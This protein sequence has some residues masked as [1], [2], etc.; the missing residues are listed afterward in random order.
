MT[1]EKKTPLDNISIN[2][3]TNQEQVKHSV[4][5]S[6]HQT[7]YTLEHAFYLQLQRFAKNN[8]LKISQIIERIDENREN[9]GLSSAIRLFILNILTDRFEP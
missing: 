3:F 8:N 2:L 4:N 5:I 6:G 7:S 1:A 9:I